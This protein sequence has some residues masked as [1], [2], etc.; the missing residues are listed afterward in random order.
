[1]EMSWSDGIYKMNTMFDLG[2]KINQQKVVL[3]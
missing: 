3:R 2:E 1:M